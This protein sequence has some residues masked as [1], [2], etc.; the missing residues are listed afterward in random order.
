MG[1]G[2]AGRPGIPWP[3]TKPDAGFSWR[4][5][6]LSKGAWTLHPNLKN[7]QSQSTYKAGLPILTVKC[8][9][10]ALCTFTRLQSRHPPAALSRTV[11]IL[12]DGDYTS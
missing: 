1:R 3:W 4:Q 12:Q 6:D 10:S 8:T 2:C 11:F 7:N 9:L 5:P